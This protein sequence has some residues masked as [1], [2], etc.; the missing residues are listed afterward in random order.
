MNDKLDNLEGMDK[1]LETYSLL[2]MELRKL[3]R[4]ITRNE[5]EYVSGKKKPPSKQNSRT[6]QLHGEILSDI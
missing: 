1:F 3:N 4:L 2:R 6:R 5:N